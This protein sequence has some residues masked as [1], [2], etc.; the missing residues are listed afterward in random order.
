EIDRGQLSNFQ[1][2]LADRHSMCF[3]MEVRVPFL[4]KKHR[5]ES[6]KIPLNWKIS[7]S[8]EKMALRE[9]AKLSGLPNR[10]INRP[11]MPAG[12]ATSPSLFNSFM[13]ELKPHAKEWAYDYGILTEQ[14]LKQPD[15]A[16]GL[17]LFHS[18]HLTQRDSPPINKNTLDI[19]DDVSIW[20]S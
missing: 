9:A 13:N 18:I 5:D 1:L 20:P 10:I 3:G 17:R 11:K 2:R 4:G 12:T 8:N 7:D 19:L 14:L 15:M 6:H 16:I